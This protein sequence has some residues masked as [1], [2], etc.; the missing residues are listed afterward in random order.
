VEW[1]WRRSGAGTERGARARHDLRERARKRARQRN[2]GSAGEAVAIV[3][4]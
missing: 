3:P 1:Q 4:V 2:G